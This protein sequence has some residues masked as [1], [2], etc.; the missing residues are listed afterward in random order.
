M[1]IRE[2]EMKLTIFAATG[3]IGRQVMEQAVAAGHDVTAVARNPKTI[4]GDVTIVTADLAAPDQKTLESAIED[5]D[6]VLSGLGRRTKSDT[7]I[8]ARGTRAIVEAMQA[9]GARRLVV[10]SAAPV[11]TVPSPGRPKPPKH[12]AG[13]GFFVRHVLTPMVK[14]ALGQTYTDLAVMEDILRDSGLDWTAVRPPR[15]TNKRLT[16]TYRSAYGRNVRGGLSISRADVAHL[17]LAVIDQPETIKQTIG[18]AY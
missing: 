7:G 16:G 8:A 11:G 13:D 9:T 2:R 3:G 5:A 18:I 14:A 12:D 1:E 4:S 6:A 15:L 10:V 17:M